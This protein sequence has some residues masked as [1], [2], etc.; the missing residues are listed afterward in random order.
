[1][2]YDPG[3]SMYQNSHHV[4]GQA[5]AELSDV[6]AVKIPDLMSGE[7]LTCL[8]MLV[9]ARACFACSHSL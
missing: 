9:H 1:M 8:C 3:I 7:H 5:R 2:T 4:D 6:V